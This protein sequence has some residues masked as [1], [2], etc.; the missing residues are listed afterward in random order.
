MIKQKYDYI[1][2]ARYCG[3]DNLPSGLERFYEEFDYYR[4]GEIIDIGFLEETLEYF[5][6]PK[7]KQEQMKSAIREI[8]EN[9]RLS[10]FTKFLIWDLCNAKKRYEDNYY[11]ALVPKCELK[12]ARYYPLLILLACVKPSM[13]MLQERGVPLTYYEKI[14]YTPMEKQF[15]KW[16]VSDDVSVS[17]FPWD[18]NFYTCSI[19]LLDRFQFIPCKFENEL[20][21][22]RN[23]ANN[24][25]IALQHGDIQV[26]R[27]GQ[28]NGT[29]EIFD[30]EKF[31]TVWEENDLTIRA[32]P[33]N[34]MGFVQRELV[35]LK[36]EEWNMALT[37]EDLLLAF[38]I[39]AGPGYTALK[40]K[41]SM[42]LALSFY[43]TY[44]SELNIKGFWSESWLYDTRL[45]LVLDYDNSNIIKVQRQFYL[46]PTKDGDDMLME[47]VFGERQIDLQSYFCKTSLQE[48][49]VQYMKSG[50]RFN[51]LSMFVLKEEVS[52]IGE[53]P[54][55]NKE[56]IER[57]KA[58]VESHLTKSTSKKD[59]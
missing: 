21:V 47:R 32:N 37:K 55:I 7:E 36:K 2:C 27:D 51:A 33:V 40:V 10:Y 31:D 23:K 53:D 56:D 4:W 24:Q 1:E 9:D 50:A 6:L 26:R 42:E 5:H 30:E 17:D 28:I 18:M 41:Q 3:F 22:Y 14:P 49:V 54:Y 45:S 8:E 19:F 15:E 43:Q 34:S 25:V 58:V 13:Q 12:Y 59:C 16:I 44:F 39:P 46:Y 52:K 20:T 29:N 38:H 35:T 48:K 57:F 11:Q